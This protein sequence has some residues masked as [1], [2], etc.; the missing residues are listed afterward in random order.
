LESPRTKRSEVQI[1]DAN[2]TNSNER[3][4][5]QIYYYY[6][7]FIHLAVFDK[8]PLSLIRQYMSL[9]PDP[10]EREEGF[11]SPRHHIID[12]PRHGNLLYS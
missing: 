11:V 5:S 8:I 1:C 4:F 3:V 9:T 7:C 12:M 2:G 10:K 6:F